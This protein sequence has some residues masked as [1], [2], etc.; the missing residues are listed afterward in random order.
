M[1]WLIF[2]RSGVTTVENILYT[3]QQQMEIVLDG[4]YIDMR[5]SVLVLDLDTGQLTEIYRIYLGGPLKVN[6]LSVWMNEDEDG[7][8]AEFNWIQMRYSMI[9]SQLD[10]HT[11]RAVVENVSKQLKAN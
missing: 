9:R 10:G 11:I 5:S 8:P 6:P 1:F 2:V 4:V 7:Q 3:I